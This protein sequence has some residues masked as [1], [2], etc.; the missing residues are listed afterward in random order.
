MADPPGTGVPVGHDAAQA[1]NRRWWDAAVPVHVDS[2]FY[3]VDGWLATGR[4]PR[5]HEIDVF[6]DVAGLDLVHLQCHFGKDTLAWARAGATVTGLDFSAPAIA[7]A[8]DLAGRAGLADRSEFVCAPVSGATTALGGRTFDIVYVS[9]G[10]LSWLPSVD[11]WA[12]QVAGLLDSGGRLFLHDV[13]PLSLAL[14]DDELTIAW[15]YFEE[16]VPYRDTPV[17]SYADPG[18]GDALAG[19]ETFSWNHG[20]GE[21]VAALLGRGLRI[22]RLDEHDWTSFPRFPWLVAADDER[23]VI[24]AGRPRVPLSFTLVASRP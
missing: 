20:I 7:A 21:T 4:G 1:A 18:A 17:G 5:R 3:D 13:H 6:G 24:P 15:T 14:D 2:D 9:L 19:G 22:D 11:E 8:R 12:G 16:P 10:A 23:Y